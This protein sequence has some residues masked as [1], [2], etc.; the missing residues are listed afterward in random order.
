MK[1]ISDGYIK[2]S[3]EL[4]IYPDYSFEQFKKTKSRGDKDCLF[5]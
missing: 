1:N 4:I 5:R 3:D 2:V